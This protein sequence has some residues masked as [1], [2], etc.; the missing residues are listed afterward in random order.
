[1]TKLK[2][3]NQITPYINLDFIE[4]FQFK[5]HVFG[6]K[7]EYVELFFLLKNNLKIIHFGTEIGE[8]SRKGFIPHEFLPWSNLINKDLPKIDVTKNQ[9]LHY[10]KGETFSLEGEKGYIIISYENQI[11]GFIKHLGNRFNNLYPKEWRIRMKID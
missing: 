10:L 11:L 8:I 3:T 9:A 2:E 1:M 6:V 5:D 7:K 4:T